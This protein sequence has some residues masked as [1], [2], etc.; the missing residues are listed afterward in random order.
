MVCRW[1]GGPGNR[2]PR[3]AGPGTEKQGKSSMSIAAGIDLGKTSISYTFLRDGEEFLISGLCEYPSLT[4]AGPQVCLQQISDGLKRAAELA[5]VEFDHIAAVGLD[6]PGPASA[7]GVLSARGSTNFAH[8]DWAGFNIRRA[9]AER[10]RKPV[11]YLNDGNAAALW[12]HFALCGAGSRAT[13]VSAIIGTG[14]GGGIVSA[15]TVVKGCRG[16]GGELGHVLIPWR[17]IIGLDGLDPMCNCGRR[18]DLESLC[19]LTAIANTLLPYFVRL[20]PAHPLATHP[21]MTE[22]S[23]LVRGMAESGDTMC[24]HI[25]RIQAHA[26]G[27]F[28]D[29]MVNVFDPDVLILGGGA[30]ETGEEFQSWFV[31]EVRADMPVQREEQAVIPIY[32]MPEGDTAGA[33][34]A[35][36]EALKLVEAEKAAPRENYVVKRA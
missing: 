14:L 27:L 4:E 26:L 19:S 3:L 30:L 2:I 25:F 7:D 21:S 8:R 10:L 28:F 11:V 36:I 1:L 32:V 15:G 12:G 23:R 31:E 5:S 9:L 24:L 33:R 20:Y 34:G 6:T 13:S 17:R 35:A 22:A 18:G 16:F 29:Q